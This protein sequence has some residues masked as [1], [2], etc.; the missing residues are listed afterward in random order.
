MRKTRISLIL[1][2]VLS[3]SACTTIQNHGFMKDDKQSY[4]KVPPLE[5]TVVIPQNL[6]SKTVQDYYEVP[7]SIEESHGE[8]SLVP[9]GSSLEARQARSQQD[10]IRTAENAKIQG[11]SSRV[12]TNGPTPIGAN[13]GE[14]WVKVGHVLQAAKYKIVEKDNTLGTY[15][16]IDTSRTNGKVKKDMPI[17]QVHLKSSGRGTIVSVSPANA[18]LQS[19]L[20]RNLND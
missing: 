12:V 15:Y 14:A 10:R 20:Y 2:A 7:Q 8:P 4:R 13:Y 5:R 18:Q 19:Q 11:H 17:Y 6:N 9:P 1:L 16:V 3:L